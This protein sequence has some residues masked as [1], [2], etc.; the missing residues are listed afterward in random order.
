MKPKRINSGWLASVWDYVQQI[1]TLILL[2]VTFFI[3]DN[4]VRNESETVIY[5][6]ITNFNK[7]AELPRV[8]IFNAD[9]Y[10]RIPTLN[11]ELIFVKL[12]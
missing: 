7:Y 3:H 2:V 5:Q 1:L 10:L 6:K 9:C 11:P 8:C 12:T 4:P